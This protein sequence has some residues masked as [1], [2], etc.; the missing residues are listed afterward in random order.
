MLHHHHYPSDQ[1][2]SLYIRRNSYVARRRSSS[3]N[4]LIPLL[5]DS[6]RAKE[7]IYRSVEA[8]KGNPSGPRSSLPL[9]RSNHSSF[10]KKR[11]TP[12]YDQAL[13]NAF[14]PPV[15]LPRQENSP[16]DSYHRKEER[17]V[18]KLPLSSREVAVY[19]QR[20]LEK[21][22]TR[23]SLKMKK[24]EEKKNKEIE[25]IQQEKNEEITKLK[26]KIKSLKSSSKQRAETAKGNHNDD[27]NA[28]NDEVS[29]DFFWELD[30]FKEELKRKDKEK[31]EF[32]LSE[33][34]N[35]DQIKEEGETKE[36]QRELMGRRNSGS[37]LEAMRERIRMMEEQMRR[38]EEMNRKE[39]MNLRKSLENE[40]QKRERP[41]EE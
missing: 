13:S 2:D 4:P 6:K 14:R 18:H 36:K 17:N 38:S 22:K 16:M 20:D 7:P 9:S 35:A 27:L 10:E 11:A 30:E 39:I 15:P 21:V 29:R 8:N 12:H 37:Q 25:K 32:L 26:E 40:K 19:S 3:P 1:L 23:F 24:L 5:N 31:V 33:R 34:K 28:R 41:I